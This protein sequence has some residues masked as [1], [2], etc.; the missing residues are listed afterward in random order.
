MG[1]FGIGLARQRIDP[2]GV[3]GAAEERRTASPSDGRE[4]GRLGRAMLRCER[5]RSAILAAAILTVKS[6]IDL[7]TR[8][9]RYV[10]V[11]REKQSSDKDFSPI[12]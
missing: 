9:A 11:R 12:A 6:G 8:K 10:F 2:E 4:R 1:S 3:S 5:Q 7:K